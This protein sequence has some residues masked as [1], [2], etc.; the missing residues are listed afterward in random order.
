MFL[1]VVDRTTAEIEVKKSRFLAVVAR[2]DSEDRARAVIAAA[3]QSNSAARHHCSA[4]VVGDL[5]GS[6]IA[7]A[8]DDGEPSGTAGTPILEVLTGR[9]LTNVVAVVSRIYG[10]TK[11]GT[12]GLARAYAGAVVE[13]L[14]TATVRRRVQ[15]RRVRVE[16]DHADVGRIEADLRA[17]GIDIVSV[18]YLSTAVLTLA[19]A[20][21]AMIES[22]LAGSTA[23][24]AEPV[25]LGT[26]Y[27]DAAV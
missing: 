10:G 25:R 2:A 20:E 9:E 5:P 19:A 24:S 26:D 17:R 16:L 6:R 11:L 8:S 21:Y 13:A 14:A 12:G 15:R 27:V 3:R 18:D 1:T 4:F 23:G 7:R 22:A